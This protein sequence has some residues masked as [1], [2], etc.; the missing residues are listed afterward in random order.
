MAMSAMARAE[1]PVSTLLV[2][3][4]LL[5]GAQ[6]STGGMRGL[7]SDRGAP[8]VID[9]DKFDGRN[10][11][12]VRASGKVHLERGGSTLDSDRL[13][14]DQISND[15]T[16]EGNVV[17]R[18]G[19]DTITGPR[20][21]INTD[22]WYG[23]FESPTYLFQRPDTSDGTRNS[24]RMVQ[25]G[26]EADIIH[27]NG[28][29]QYRLSN[30]TYSTCPAP[31]PDWYM[32]MSDLK[33]DYDRDQGEG[34]H[35]TMVFKD[36]P[37]AYMPWMSF[38]LSGGRQ[39]GLLPPTFGST[40]NTGLDLTLPYYFNLAPNYDATIAPRWMGRRG[41]QV[42]GEFR[43]L[44]PA[45]TGSIS[46]EYLPGDQ[47][48]GEDRSLLQIKHSQNFGSGFSGF[49][50]YGE[51]SDSNY[52]TDLSTR[53]TSTSTT[54]LNQQA[55]LN[56]NSGTWLSGA[57]N[58]QRYQVL[59]DKPGD[60]PYNRLPQLSALATLPDWH[61]LSLTLP[62]DFTAFQIDSVTNKDEGRR[63]VIYPQVGY[64]LQTPAWY[65]TPKV[66]LH[67]THYDLDRRSTTGPDT[68]D[69]TVPIFTVDSGMNF[70]R[71]TTI[72]GKATTQTLEPRLYYVKAAYRNQN[73]Y[74]IF[75]TALAD[76]NFAQLF[77]ENTYAGSDRIVDANQLTAALATRFIESDSGVEWL[78]MGI[79]QRFY[80]ADQRVYAP[81]DRP[82]K[83][84]ESHWLAA[85][86]GR[87]Y[88][89]VWLDTAYEYNPADS[90][91][92]RASAGIR[93]QAD[94]A[95]VISASYRYKYG[96]RR[97]PLDNTP[98]SGYRDLDISI[99]WPVFGN[100]YGVG[101]Y[102]R[103]LQDQMLT[104][105]IAGLEYKADCWVFRGVWQTLLNTSGNRNNAW[106]LQLEF[107]GLASVGSSPV[108]LLK[109]SIGGYGKIND[110]ASVGDPVFGGTSGSY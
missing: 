3:P 56:Y 103:N 13:I 19:E 28:E 78:R 74:P 37:I 36:V 98:G 38:P 51:V 31:D 42:N 100:W 35:T 17:M 85:L 83:A 107:N 69:R 84:G 92:E 34:A 15:A 39:S 49:V 23:E 73:D 55:A 20:A 14:F 46:A 47:V 54:Q 71:D 41:L 29:N 50:D 72:G 61:G 91:T 33:L 80:F 53:I 5:V 66:G 24:S 81:G 68:L 44:T 79:G 40:S 70:E 105:A 22:T 6:A 93:Y 57:L 30:A 7:S 2:D 67:M 62:M 101:R 108:Q 96:T 18:R 99:Q 52:F 11:V 32:K 1:E 75:D 25:G 94:F 86:S 102:N 43:Y 60:I 97:N 95:K 65:V 63:G 12:E 27:L 89:K 76:F 88:D 64:T 104:E 26:G 10:D 9:A 21:R 4:R 106:F 109:R 77:A 8:T 58:V 59:S 45:Y 48:T 110:S 16:A 90:R 87:M 82:Q